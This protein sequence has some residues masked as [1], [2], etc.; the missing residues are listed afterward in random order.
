MAKG[1]LMSMENLHSLLKIFCVLCSCAKRN[2]QTP[3]PKNVP[4]SFLSQ[5]PAE[6]LQNIKTQED[7][8]Q[9]IIFKRSSVF[10]LFGAFVLF[11]YAIFC[12]HE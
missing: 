9:I 3:W 12:I 4:Q 6:W 8:Q 2:K 1:E 5:D 11:F 7:Q 10:A